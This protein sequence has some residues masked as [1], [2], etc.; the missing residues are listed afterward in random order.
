MVTEAGGTYGDMRGGPYQ[1]GGKTLTV[2]NGA[3]HQEMLDLFG[4][5]FA[6]KHRVPMPPVS[7]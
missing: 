2:S 4:D 3:I 6:G 5:V 7:D 1:L